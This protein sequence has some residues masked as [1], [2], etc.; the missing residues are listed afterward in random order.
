MLNPF[1]DLLYFS[2]LVPVILRLSIGSFFLLEGYSRIF[3]KREQFRALFVERWQER[4]VSLLWVAG[5]LE[6]TIG[7]MFFVG[8]YTQIAA[9][10]AIL[11][12]ITASFV[13][14]GFLLLVRGKMLYL[15]ILA[16]TLSLLLSGAG[17]FSFDL[18]L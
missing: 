10:L 13:Q 17:P 11:L 3:T 12:V 6:V 14:H 1:P 16:I 4:G 7:A 2:L 18:P 9:L 5:I 15:F 8:F